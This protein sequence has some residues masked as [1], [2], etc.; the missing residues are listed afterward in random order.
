MHGSLWGFVYYFYENASHDIA[1]YEKVNLTKFE[2]IK[3]M[4]PY[5]SDQIFEI[6][7]NPQ[8]Y[9]LV[10]YKIGKKFV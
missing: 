5:K 3:I 1:L 8:E 4:P 2:N 9:K 6:D 10:L 7:C